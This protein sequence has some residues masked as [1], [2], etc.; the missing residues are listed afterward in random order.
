MYE[1]KKNFIFHELETNF[2]LNKDQILYLMKSQIRAK[3]TFWRKLLNFRIEYSY[4]RLFRKNKTQN[5]SANSNVIDSLSLQLK[6][7]FRI[8]YFALFNWKKNICAQ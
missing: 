7:N 3:K 5:Y 4:F 8:E 6:L 1:Y 2:R